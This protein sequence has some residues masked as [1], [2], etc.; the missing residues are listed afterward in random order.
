MVPPRAHPPSDQPTHRAYTRC[1][2]RL[3]HGEQRC[4]WSFAEVDAATHLHEGDALARL[5][6]FGEAHDTLACQ[7]FGNGCVPLALGLKAARPQ[8]IALLLSTERM[9]L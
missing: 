1:V 4:A 2:C 3:L 8:Y 6:T 9:R 5:A 7:L